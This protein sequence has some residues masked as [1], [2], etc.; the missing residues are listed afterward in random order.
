MIH[1]V[2][3]NGAWK[4]RAI[5]AYRRL[6]PARRRALRWMRA[7][8]PGTVHTDLL[9]SGLIPDPHKGMAELEAQWV[10]HPAMG[11]S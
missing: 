10:E 4:F 11:V 3:L 9:A 1:I 7:S 6:P 8:V 5:D 2:D